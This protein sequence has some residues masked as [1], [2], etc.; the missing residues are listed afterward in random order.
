MFVFPTNVSSFRAIVKPSGSF[1]IILPS[2]STLKLRD[3]PFKFFSSF[4]DWKKGRV[5]EQSLPLFTYHVWIA[6]LNGPP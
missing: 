3:I 6:R 1:K 4:N 5:A 2:G